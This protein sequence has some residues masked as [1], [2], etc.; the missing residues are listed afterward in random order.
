MSR[1]ARLAY[2]AR[3]LRVVSVLQSRVLHI[4]Y[5]IPDIMQL[6]SRSNLCFQATSGA[7]SC[8]I[9]EMLILRRFIQSRTISQANDTR[10][11]A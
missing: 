7:L 9:H 6:T 8:F 1:R 11:Q 5:Y 3:K 10:K 4:S 2:A